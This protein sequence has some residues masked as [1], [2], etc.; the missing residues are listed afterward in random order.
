MILI[1]DSKSGS[2]PE[3]ISGCFRREIGYGRKKLRSSLH[4]LFL[5]LLL[6]AFPG[7]ATYTEKIEK[8]LHAYRAGRMEE[9]RETF[10]N[11]L[12]ESRNDHLARLECGMAGLALRNPD[13]AVSDFSRAIDRMDSL[14]RGSAARDTASYLLD[15]TVR[16][17]VGAPYEQICSRAFLC[18]AYMI[19]AG[20]FEDVAAACRDMDGKM[21]SIEAWYNRSYQC[22]DRGR[23]VEFAFQIPP[24]AKYLAALVEERNG[25]M[26][27]A[28]LYMKQALQ[29][30][31]D[32]GYFRAE[33]RRMQRRSSENRVFVFA[34][35][36][37]TP[38]KIAT[39]SRELTGLLEGIKT[40]LV[41]VDPQNNPDAVSRQ[42]LT[43]PVKIPAYPR[44]SPFW[45]GGFE[46]KA[47]DGSGQTVTDAVA[48][49]DRYAREEYDALLPGLLIRTAV[50]RTIKEAAGQ[51]IGKQF[52]GEKKKGQQKAERAELAK[53]IGDFFGSLF[54]A[55]ETVDT[56]SWCTLPRELHAACLEVEPG[57]A[58][59]VLAPRSPAGGSLGGRI[60]VPLD[61]SQP[62]PAV[63]IVVHPA[64]GTRPIVIVDEAH[65]RGAGVD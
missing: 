46:V 48:D 52:E 13:A 8:G 24:V 36:G 50:R 22:Y 28:G 21:E 10:E 60:E 11:T 53:L 44:R 1:W 45:H 15:D 43:A 32:C 65:R 20:R 55:V 38:H 35:L 23:P 56:R 27:N 14:V 6:A 58:S 47:K 9:A 40:V 12:G 59:I 25:N 41:W 51:L 33:A 37:M 62:G 49:F 30:M 5:L 61:L 7:C 4:F 34:L 2:V 16:D 3:K 29:S 17:Y 19:K 64:R 57:T 42:N 18:L 54:A 26:D 63:V 39:V 31:P